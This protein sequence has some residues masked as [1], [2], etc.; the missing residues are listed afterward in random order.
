MYQ[1]IY[2]IIF[3]LINPQF[4]ANIEQK[5]T[6][7]T[8]FNLAFRKGNYKK[9]IEV[10]EKIE[11]VNRLIEPELRLDAAHAYFVT[12]DTLNAR[13]NYEYTQDLPNELQS[14]QS[15][16]QLGVLAIIRGDSALGLKYFKKAIEKNTNL[17]QARYNYELISNL[18]K[19]RSSPPPEEQK[20]K[21]S[22]EIIASDKKEQDLEQYTS[23]KISKE[24]AL[25]LLD[26]LKN[27]EI[28]ILIS[29]KNSK[30]NLEKDW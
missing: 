2:H 9:S 28:K 13:I 27:S 19:P 15:C 4:F 8:E 17:D 24:K 10:F 23:K 26:D 5:N 14:S 11:N 12:N 6:Y 20:S 21:Q 29:G 1:F 3:F 22:Q 30:R 16:N 7:K 25:Q 18:H